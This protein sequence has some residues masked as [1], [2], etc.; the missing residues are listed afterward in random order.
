MVIFKQ[1]IC[2]NIMSCGG[3][4]VSNCGGGYTSHNSSSCGG[5]YVSS[6]GGGCGGYLPKPPIYHSEC[7][8]YVSSLGCGGS[9]A[10]SYEKK[11]PMKNITITDFDEAAALVS[12][13]TGLPKSLAKSLI[14]E[15][16]K[17]W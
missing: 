8:G 10:P 14:M 5:G 16:K 9:Y 15:K 3:S 2:V 11:E 13:L 1:K 6:C 4:F 12:E 17:N 7:G